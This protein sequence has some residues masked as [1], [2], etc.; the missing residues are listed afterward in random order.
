MLFKNS[1]ST[2]WTSLD[3]NWLKEKCKIE[4]LQNAYWQLL[5]FHRI[6]YK[7]SFCTALILVCIFTLQCYAASYFTTQLHTVFLRSSPNNS[8]I[9][10][11]EEE[12][13]RHHC[14]LFVVII[15]IYW[16]PPNI[17]SYIHSDM[18]ICYSQSSITSPCANVLKPGIYFV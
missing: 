5:W 13:K 11:V 15:Y 6:F 16:Q 10:C 12:S 8:I 4:H 1:S 7:S 2:F 14:Q 9:S 3:E 18:L 17:Y